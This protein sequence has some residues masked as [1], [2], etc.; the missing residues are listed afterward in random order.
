[1]V[2]I[3]FLAKTVNTR[4]QQNFGQPEYRSEYK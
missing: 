1:M 2:E 4:A 3:R